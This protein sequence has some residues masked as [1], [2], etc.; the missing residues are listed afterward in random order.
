MEDENENG[1]FSG[2]IKELK[3]NVHS[4]DVKGSK[5]Y[6]VLFDNQVPI[7]N[8]FFKK[9]DDGLSWEDAKKETIN[10][11][12]DIEF[13]GIP[14]RVKPRYQVSSRSAYVFVELE[15]HQGIQDLIKSIDRDINL[16]KLLD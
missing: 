9:I 7:M 12:I 5:A 2:E 15:K 4:F 11:L 3:L 1:L 10:K 8:E 16:G 14:D 13:P 6:C